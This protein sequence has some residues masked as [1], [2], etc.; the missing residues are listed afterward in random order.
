MSAETLVG[1]DDVITLLSDAITQANGPGEALLLLGERGIGKTA[2]LLAAEDIARSAECEV[3]ETA[4]SR[5]ESELPF[6]ALHRLLRPLLPR[7]QTLPAP[8]RRALLTALGIHD[9]RRPDL[10]AVSLATV[11]LVSEAASRSRVVLTVDDMPLLDQESRH[12]LTFLARRIERRRVVVVATSTD[13]MVPTETW[14]ALRSIPLRRLDDIAAH[15][16]LAR[17][18]PALDRTQRRWVMDH[19]VG[20]PLALVELGRSA[21]DRATPPLDAPEPILPLSP[22]LLRAF[23]DCLAD[24]PTSSRDAVLV[25]ALTTADSLQEV[26]AAATLLGGGTVTTAALDPAVALGLLSYDDTRIRMAHPLVRSAVARR[27]PAS[28]RQAAQRALGEVVTMN[29]RRRTWHRA[30]GATGPDDKIAADLERHGYDSIRHGDAAAAVPALRRAAALSTTAGER[31]RR[32]LLGA[33]QAALLGDGDT[34]AQ[35]R[36]EAMSDDLADLDRMRAELLAGDTLVATGGTS[37]IRRLC[38]H[39][40]LALARQDVDLGMDLGYAAALSASSRPSSARTRR[41]VN[42]LTDRLARRHPEAR[43]VAMWALIDS[44]GNGRAVASALAEVDEDADGETLYYLGVAAHAVG[45][46]VR[47]LQLLDRAEATLRARGLRGTLGGVLSLSADMHFDVG[48]WDR[49][50][51]AL[52]EAHTLTSSTGTYLQVNLM[53]TAAK[54]AALRGDVARALGLATQVEQH[55]STRRGSGALTRAQV[56]RGIAGI[57]S[58]RYLEAMTS[59]SRIFDPRDPSHHRGEQSRA[60]MYLAEAAARSGQPDDGRS[61]VAMMERTTGAA[62]SPLLTT[63]LAYA[64]AVLSADDDAEQLHLAGLASELAAWPWPRARLQLS[65]GRWL[66]RHHQANRARI[67]LRTAQQTL[68]QLGAT[69]WAREALDELD[70]AGQRRDEVSAAEPLAALLSTQEFKIARLV[71]EG[72][73]NSEI[74]HRLALSSRTVGSHLYRIFPK[75]GVSGRGQIAARFADAGITD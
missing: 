43:A 9:G 2:C 25:A 24:L 64:R 1:R 59:L 21:A 55:P 38:A 13:S 12:V 17:L 5:A 60:I 42:A 29:S 62:P 7:T 52:A 48:D 35:L 53:A 36:T 39:A 26:I 27:E 65:F 23:G 58:G 63:Q 18:A 8:Q 10:L 45:D 75:L 69:A 16:L 72:L 57:S 44:A 61:I 3:L 67:P 20:N 19:A 70:A 32:L 6:A 34:V 31:G 66:R 74:G 47:G 33:R 49:G 46:Y 40:D 73:S 4:G 11:E 56:A 50:E 15:R 28:R 54:A 30:Y 71:C 22:A 14:G 68:H 41:A 37:A 51:T